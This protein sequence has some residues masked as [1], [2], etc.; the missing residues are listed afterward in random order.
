MHEKRR[1]KLVK[2]VLF[3]DNAQGGTSLPLFTYTSKSPNEYKLH[4]KAVAQWPRD[5]HHH[6]DHDHWVLGGAIVEV[7]QRWSFMGCVTKNFISLFRA[8]KGKLSHWYQL[9]LQSLAPTN[10][11]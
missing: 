5:H 1:D 9:H 6:H 8:S 11:H 10:P 3:L 7:K 4:S 2:I